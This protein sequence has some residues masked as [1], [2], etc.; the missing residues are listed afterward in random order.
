MTDRPAV[1]ADDQSV[2]GSVALVVV[3][4]GDRGELCIGTLQA[5]EAAGVRHAVVVLN[6]VTAQSASGLAAY[7]AASPASVVLIHEVMNTG[8]AP[9]FGRGLAEARQRWAPDYFWLLDDDTVPSGAALLAEQRLSQEVS[10][11]GVPVAVLGF[12]S[13]IKQQRQAFEYGSAIGY[14]TNSSFMYFDLLRRLRLKTP[15]RNPQEVS[16]QGPI[17]VPYGPYGGLLIPSQLQQRIGLPNPALVLYEDDTEYLARI[18]PAGGR[19]VLCRDAEIDDIVSNWLADTTGPTSGP[20]R[21]LRSSSP[22]KLYYSTRNRVY[23]DCRRP[24]NNKLLL[25]A[26]ALIYL[27]VVALS[28]RSRVQFNA[29]RLIARA[30]L[31]GALARLGPNPSFPLA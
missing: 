21:L 3:T 12:R 16:D 19:L 6:G 14:P 31:D 23:F 24:N 26:N 28:I 13:S 30:V 4:Y 7:A 10:R 29:A 1:G 5:A 25:L 9:A 18:A 8:S 15:A 22:S 17:D 27:S 2:R 11:T 20:A